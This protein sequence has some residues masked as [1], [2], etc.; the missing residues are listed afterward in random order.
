M[1]VVS[2]GFSTP[3][4]GS[5]LN[6]EAKE[7]RG[8][9]AA[10]AASLSFLL[11][12]LLRLATEEGSK[13]GGESPRPRKRATSSSSS[14][15]CRGV[16]GASG[17]TAPCPGSSSGGSSSKGASILPRFCS[18][19]VYSCSVFTKASPTSRPS[20]V[21]MASGP[22][23]VATHVTASRCSRPCTSR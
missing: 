18:S 2:L 21:N 1:S 6:L 5:K 3:E 17:V 14:S 19:T 13:L 15:S 8:P 20:S 7:R 11:P 4:E 12:L 16:A 10:A 22:W 9:S 23:P